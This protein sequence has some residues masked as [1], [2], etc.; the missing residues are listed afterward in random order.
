VV[1]VDEHRSGPPFTGFR[2]VVNHIPGY[3]RFEERLPVF[4]ILEC[5][6]ELGQEQ[7]FIPGITDTI[8]VAFE[9]IPHEHLEGRSVLLPPNRS[10]RL[11]DCEST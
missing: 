3:Q 1:A 5:T 11:E 10:C 8:L 9:R 4:V 6:G 7:P 2:E